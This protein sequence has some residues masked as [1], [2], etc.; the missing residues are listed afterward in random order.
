MENALF[1]L[2]WKEFKPEFKND[3]KYLTQVNVVAH[4]SATKSSM[5]THRLFLH[6]R[7]YRA[8]A[9]PNTET[10]PNLIPYG[11]NKMAGKQS[12][13]RLNSSRASHRGAGFARCEAGKAFCFG[14]GAIIRAGKHTHAHALWGTFEFFFLFS[15]LSAPEHP[16]KWLSSIRA[17]NMVIS[18]QLK[19]S[20]SPEIIND[21]A[22][23]KTS[24]FPG[25]Q[26]A[27][28]EH[29]N[30]TPELYLKRSTFIIPGVTSPAQLAE[31][32]RSLVGI[33]SKYKL[34]DNVSSVLP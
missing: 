1:S 26:I 5:H 10:N 15:K 33:Y 14:G 11:S 24:K 31:I 19:C 23:T 2:H 16:S 27:V 3:I 12:H 34:C 7:I 28:P 30:S 6:N 22:C 20:I 9:P 13:Y 8:S 17:P 25:I 18:G 4:A 21:P 29:L 32:L